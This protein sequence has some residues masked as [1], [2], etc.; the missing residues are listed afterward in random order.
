MYDRLKI[1]R[2]DAGDARQIVTVP[3]AGVFPRKECAVLVIC[4]PYR[5]I[6]IVFEVISVGSEAYDTRIRFILITES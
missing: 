3:V 6:I 1:V 4:Y 5:L 2:I